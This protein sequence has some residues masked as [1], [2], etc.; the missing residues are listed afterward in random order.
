M[1][2]NSQSTY[3]DK[4][5]FAS[6]P[7][8]NE[9][10][11]TIF[12]ICD[13]LPTANTLSSSS[14]NY[15][16]NSNPRPYP[17]LHG[18]E[19]VSHFLQQFGVNHIVFTHSFSTAWVVQ[20]EAE[21]SLPV[22]AVESQYVSVTVN[23]V[24]KNHVHRV[25]LAQVSRPAGLVVVGVGGGGLKEGSEGSGRRREI[26]VVVVG[27]GREA[28]EVDVTENTN[29]E[30]VCCVDELKYVGGEAERWV[31]HIGEDDVVVHWR[32]K[33]FVGSLHDL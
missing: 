21:Q 28:S 5:R 14:P 7:I 15:P 20:S 8:P 22:H 31:N 9:S 17:V 3:T 30:S 6:K 33:L 23:H 32:G 25:V 11:A 1:Q 27:G 26:V 4:S 10:V 29:V 16:S 19:V 12:R 24:G 18:I 2:R 13:V